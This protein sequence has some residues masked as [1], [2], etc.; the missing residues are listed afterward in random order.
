VLRTLSRWSDRLAVDAREPAGNLQATPFEAEIIVACVRWYLRFGLSFRNLEELMVERNVTV[1][2][3]T[4]WRWVQRYAPE[5]RRR[6]RPELRITNRSW[7]VDETY[8]R[9]AGK[10]TYYIERWTP[11]APQ[12]ISA[13]C[14]PGR[15][16][17][18][19][20]LPE[21][22]AVSW[23]P[24]PT[25]DQRGWESGIPEGHQKTRAGWRTR[26]PLSLSAGALLE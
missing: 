12:L 10:W 19:A 13:V 7:C 3:V 26:T 4:I 2:H 5:L 15:R 1:D 8:L 18:E 6:C 20:L 11:L 16:R 14:R 24:T 21:S 23:S 22:I 17:C 25:G 9:V